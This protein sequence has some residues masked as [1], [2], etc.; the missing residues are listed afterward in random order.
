MTESKYKCTDHKLDL[1]CP[2]C[3]RAWITRHDKPLEFVK[4]C[5]ET[6]SCHACD[7]QALL[8]AKLLKE[9]GE[10]HER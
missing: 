2:G 7:H 8:A 5:K 9:I 1:V 4:W 10:E 6:A 3:V